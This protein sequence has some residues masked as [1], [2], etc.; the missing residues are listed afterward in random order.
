MA[1][2]TAIYDVDQ[3]ILFEKALELG[4]V[5]KEDENLIEHGELC[6]LLT[7]YYAD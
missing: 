1:V 3:E 5:E 6:D 4:I 7:D 2:R